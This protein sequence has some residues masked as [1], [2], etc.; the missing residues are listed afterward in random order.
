MRICKR[1]FD[2]NSPCSHS[3]P[4][5]LDLL[6]TITHSAGRGA[7]GFGVTVMLGVVVVLA[8]VAQLV[9]LPVFVD[10]VQSPYFALVS[11]HIF[12]DV[13][14]ENCAA[15]FWDRSSY[16]FYIAMSALIICVPGERER[17][18]RVRLRSA[19]G[20]VYFLPAR[21]QR[22]SRVPLHAGCS[23]ALLVAD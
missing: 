6:F 4:I 5:F 16:V 23:R 19:V 20:A 1:L 17:V 3:N 18:S 10:T 22:L 11:A 7:L 2:P 21:H 12:N 14:D 9:A 15:V 8:R 13:L